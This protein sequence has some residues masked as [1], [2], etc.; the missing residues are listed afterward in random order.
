MD[1]RVAQ[2][3]RVFI[4]TGGAVFVASIALVAWYYGLEWSP[5]VPFAGWTAVAVNA[6][7]FSVFALHHSLFARPSVKQAMTSLVA[8]RLQR[9]V[10]VWIASLLFIGVLLTWREV[11]GLVYRTSGVQAVLQTA[12]QLIG[13]WLIAGAVRAIDPLEL[14]GIRSETVGDLQTRGPYKRVRHPLYLGWVILVLGP[15]TMT[16]D[17]LAF[18]L[19]SS[20]YLFIAVPWEEKGLERTFGEQYTQ[21]KKDVRWRIVPFVY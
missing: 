21:Y 9:A 8:E 7:L 17:R 19:I 15:P 5:Q 12:I 6:V 20:A 3:E 4:W 13:V 11:G 1:R 2:L 18:A 14:A 10:Y 16:G